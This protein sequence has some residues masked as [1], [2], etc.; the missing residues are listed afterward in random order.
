MSEQFRS[1]DP[2]EAARLSEIAYE[3]KAIWGYT[4][5]FLQACRPEL[6]YSEAQIRSD[7][8]SF[9]I[10]ENDHDIAGFYALEY[11]GAGAAE[12]E[13]LFVVPRYIGQSIGLRL[14]EHAKKQASLRGAT[15][16]V[17]QAD[18][19]AAGFYEAAGGVPAG[20]RESLS[21]PGRFLPVYEIRLG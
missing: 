20:E 11:S 14:L 12:L 1:A 19:N 7:T 3:A 15:S 13:A 2:K 17:I 21:I 6:T 5:E 9:V 4:V 18:P 10:F 16:L 8:R